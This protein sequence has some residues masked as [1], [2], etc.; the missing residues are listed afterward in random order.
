MAAAAHGVRFGGL[1]D[2]AVAWFLAITTVVRLVVAMSEA[3]LGQ[4]HE[5]KGFL[6]GGVATAATGL[7]CPEHFQRLLEGLKLRFRRHQFGLQF[8]NAVGR[9]GCC[10]MRSAGRHIGLLIGHVAEDSGC[11]NR[12]PQLRHDPV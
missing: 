7:E 5:V 2:V 11:I 9:V 6:K 1:F 3:I 4:G 8:H 10:E 12:G